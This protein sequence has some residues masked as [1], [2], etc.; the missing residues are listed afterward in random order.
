MASM[1]LSLRCLC[2]SKQPVPGRDARG[3]CRS[4]YKVCQTLTKDSLLLQQYRRIPRRRVLRD[5]LYRSRA[6]R[7]CYAVLGS[8]L[9]PSMVTVSKSQGRGECQ[10]SQAQAIQEPKANGHQTQRSQTPTSTTRQHR[11]WPSSCLGW[12]E[13]QDPSVEGAIMQIKARRDEMGRTS[14]SP[15]LHSPARRQQ[16][17]FYRHSLV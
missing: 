13:L 17:A 15:L 16:R 5:R 3:D 9:V 14:R 10:G 6:S 12:V 8:A 11:L 7:G 2:L 1:T 4:L